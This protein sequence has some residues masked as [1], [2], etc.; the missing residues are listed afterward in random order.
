MNSQCYLSLRTSNVSP[1]K[2]WVVVIL[3][4]IAQES[5]I[6]TIRSHGA[7]HVIQIANAAA[8]RLERT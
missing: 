5:G 8:G 6:G 4:E 3:D 2:T 7:D 1:C